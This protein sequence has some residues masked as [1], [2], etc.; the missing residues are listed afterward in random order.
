MTKPQPLLSAL[1][2][3]TLAAA[4]TLAACTASDGGG[5]PAND[6]PD[7]AADAAPPPPPAPPPDAPPDAPRV[8][9]DPDYLEVLPHHEA[10][11]KILCDRK[12]QDT[13]SKVFCAKPGGPKL[14]GLKDLAAALG[15]GFKDPTKGNGTLGNPAFA[16]T[17]HSSSLVMRHV[18]AANPRVVVFTPPLATGPNPSYVAL[19]FTR[20]E[21]LV[22]LATRDPSTGEPAFYLL[23]YEQPCNATKSCTT[24][25]LVGPAT[26]S[27]WTG[28]TLY[29]D[30]DLA[31]TA[32]DC[33]RCHQPNAKQRPLLRM[34]ERVAP[35]THWMAASTAGG[36][37]LLAD[38]HAVH[39]HAEDYGTIPAALFDASDPS[40]LAKL[41]DQNNAQ[42]PQPNA[43]DAAAIER[44]V[45]A[46]SPAQP[47]L[48]DPPGKSATWQKIF[49]VAAGAGA[50]RVPYHD[51]KVADG[52]RLDAFGDAYRAM[53][54]GKPA[55]VAD[56][57]TL[58]LESAKVDLGL[59]PRPG[60]SGAEIVK[61]MCGECHNGR[62]D[63]T[64]SRARFDATRL[65]AMPPS[66]RAIAAARVALP[67][68]DRLRMP[69]AVFGELSAEE[70]AKVKEALR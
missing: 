7:A 21:Q 23:K 29:E 30:E 3:A 44:E 5:D 50:I 12:G 60:A 28:W 47:T 62:L 19:G 36:R 68:S 39:G 10:Q 16:V 4:A 27:G 53:V 65:E 34:Q 37:A 45:L 56:P 11:L 31:N 6:A 63:P 57:R 69:P 48:N 2:G 24:R 51:V 1:L 38:H 40:L 41:V 43:F 52:A 15:L 25:D 14:T 22:E 58:M 35:F 54:A 32:V 9:H 55:L 67:A 46:S 26:E 61:Q 42:L 66:E 13:V 18:N 70:I 64:L 59:R 17:G 8:D 33:L 49:D 20:G